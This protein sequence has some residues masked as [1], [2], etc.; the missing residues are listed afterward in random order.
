MSSIPNEPIGP[1][2]DWS[3]L[4]AELR[5]RPQW[6]LAGPNK[7]PLTADGRA[8]SVT[9]PATW[10]DFDTAIRSAAA[11]GYSIGYIQ[12]TEDPFSCIDMD[13][14]DGTAQASLD[15]YQSIIDQFDSYTERSQSGRGFHVWVRAKIGDGRRRDGVEVYSQA[16]FMICTGNVVRDRPI[17]ER[18]EQLTNMVSQMAPEAPAV[19]ELWGEQQPDWSAAKFAVEDSGELGRLFAG[20]W[21][22]RYPSQS[23]ADLALVML[24][25]P[26]TVSPRECWE[27]FRLSRLGK[28]EK[29]KR[30]DYAQSTIARAVQLLATEGAQIEDGRLIAA[31]LDG[32]GEQA[33]AKLL[34]KLSVNW[35]DEADAEVPDII[36][37][38]VADEDV[39]LLGGHGGIGKS[40]LALQMACAVATGERVLH[41]DTRQCRVLY[42]S[43]EDGRKRLT[44]RLQRLIENAGHDET[45]LKQNLRVL[46]ASEVEPLYG[47]TVEHGAGK[48]PS[49][50]KMLGPRA[51]FDKLQSMVSAFDP[52]LVVIDGA[53]DTFDG[54]EIARREVR[55]FIK[56]LRR[57]HPA[58]PIA[59]LV[60]VHIDRSSARGN[61]TNDDGYAG[62]AQWHNSCRRRLFLQQDVRREKDEITEEWG[63]VLGDI[64]LRVMKNQDGPPDP[65]MLLERGL[66]G[67]WQVG[68]TFTGTLAFKD[69]T[70]HGPT[71][72]RLISEYYRRATYISTSLAPQAHTGVYATLRSDPSFPKGM[73]RKRTT[74]L[75]RQLQRDG[76]LTAER[77]QRGNR[78]WAE[79]W[80]VA[81]GPDYAN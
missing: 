20:D 65:D 30:S 26:H 14:K 34:E 40:F 67:L 56:L 5:D 21:Q 64:K 33:G 75:V 72:L 38:L 2:A 27:T 39:T 35:D 79:R 66:H 45:L 32:N 9:D 15:R 49:F 60:T 46:D 24:L 59:V 54:N 28:R 12:T 52:Q 57:V 41:R 37:G 44:R 48:R 51:D 22:D 55:A 43:A 13:V 4:P 16:R 29:A 76:M 74:E 36:E 19:I 47:E 68:V 6:C 71:V 11:R 31:T 3:R 7:R 58:R 70:D 73:S 78:T 81:L 62:S 61:T 53:S 50:V 42:Y 18:Q 63:M 77:Y 69:E 17:A 10:T 1:Q 25:L 80:A 8:A 23:E